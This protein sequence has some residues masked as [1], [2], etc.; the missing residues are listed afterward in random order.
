AVKPASPDAANIPPI[1]HDNPIPTPPFW[2]HRVV[3]DLSPR[4]LFPYINETALFRGQWGFK[5][6]KLSPE[7]FEK[8]TDEKARP[9]FE[10]LKKRAVEEGF[11]QPKVVYG[12]FPV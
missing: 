4:Y 1:K 3:T 11:L 5:Q 6:G 7:E 2:G 9:V 8:L 10:A 12:Y